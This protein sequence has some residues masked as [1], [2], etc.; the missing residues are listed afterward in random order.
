MHGALTSPQ[1]LCYGEKRGKR[2]I[3]SAMADDFKRDDKDDG[4]DRRKGPRYPIVVTV[5]VLRG[6][7]E[8]VFMRSR[9]FG[10]TGAFLERLDPETTLPVIGDQ[11]ELRVPMGDVTHPSIA[12]GHAVVIRVEDNGVA[13]Q[14]SH[15]K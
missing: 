2:G 6:E 3:Q 8:F 1:T 10:P 11:I 9:D 12:S 14:F 13:V 7:G 15:G 5:R 4:A